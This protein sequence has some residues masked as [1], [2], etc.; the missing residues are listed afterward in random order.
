MQASS[1]QTKSTP[2]VHNLRTFKRLLGRFRPVWAPSAVLGLMLLLR[3]AGDIAYPYLVG[4]VVDRLVGYQGSGQGLPAGYTVLIALLA[5]V[6]AFRAILFY[7]SGVQAARVSQSVE[8]GLRRD[9][10]R[11]VTEL[12]FRYHDANRSGATIVRS[13]RDMEKT[14]HFFREVFF[15]YVEIVLLVGAVLIA[16]YWTHWGYGLIV[17]LTFGLGIGAC[18]L[19]ARKVA[20]MD[21][22]VSEVYDGVTTVLQE[23][24]AGARVVRA[25]GREPNE[26]RKFGTH[27]DDLSQSWAR[28]ERFWTGLLPLVN[29]LFALA[30]PLI[31]GLGAWRVSQG[32]GGIGEVT[33]VMLYCRTVHH[34][35]R[36]LTRLVIVGQQ[37][38]ASASRVFEVLDEGEVFPRLES[39]VTLPDRGGNVRFEDVRFAHNPEVPVLQGVSLEIPAGTSLGIIGPTGAGKSSL[40]QL[41]PRFYDPD[42]GRVLLDG[43]DVQDLDVHELRAAVGLVFQEAFPV[44]RNGGRERRLRPAG[45]RPGRGRALRPVGRRR[46]LRT[47]AARR[48]RDRRRRAWCESLGRTAS[49]PHHRARA[50]HAA[51]CAHLPTTPR[52]AW[53]PSRRRSCSRASSQRPADARRW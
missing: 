37:A 46:G 29:H 2:E 20:Q 11:K 4:S 35:I 51:A 17:T 1:E 50:G 42:A 28:L 53:T 9:L 7:L 49:A 3:S 41:L 26:V 43:I 24:V 8:N 47:R 52:R 27:M 44:L 19:A 38:T 16:S 18:V 12:R 25:F 32:H 34:R 30:V 13:L 10:F 5:G 14:R 39:P 31:V 15:G 21:R 40:V 45:D 6:I 36:P 48:L 33:A 23:N 22:E